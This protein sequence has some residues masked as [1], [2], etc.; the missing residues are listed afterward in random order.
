MI[1]LVDSREQDTE[2]ARERYKRFPCKYE[3]CKLEYGDYSLNFQLPNEKWIYNQSSDDVKINPFIAIERKMNLDELAQCF[4]KERK[5]FEAEFQRAL[6]H[7]ARIY[8]L[9]ENGSWEHLING[10]YRSKFNANAFLA[11]VLAWSAR[12]NLQIIFCKEE[13]T[14]E[15][16]YNI[17]YRELKEKLER[18]EFDCL[19]NNGT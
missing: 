17:L 6:E 16:I 10:K 2:R 9:V 1:I 18:G 4:T 7:N 3:K 15:L 5:R 19:E 14:A 8:L 11:S 12:Y 13:T